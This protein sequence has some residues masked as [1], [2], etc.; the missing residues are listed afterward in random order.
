MV[1]KPSSRERPPTCN[2]CTQICLWPNWSKKCFTLILH[3]HSFSVP[4][5]SPTPGVVM[6][7]RLN[8]LSEPPGIILWLQYPNWRNATTHAS[9]SQS[10]PLSW[11]SLKCWK[12]AQQ[13]KLVASPRAPTNKQESFLTSHP[14]LISGSK[15]PKEQKS[16]CHLSHAK[17]GDIPSGLGL[18]CQPSSFLTHCSNHTFLSSAFT[19][20]VLTL[21][22]EETFIILRGGG[23]LRHPWAL[24]TAFKWHHTENPM[25]TDT[26]PAPLPLREVNV[27]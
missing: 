7:F 27:G 19:S 12:L 24:N 8:C 5:P 16:G 4:G 6:V 3:S 15:W 26:Q 21:L 13:V 10:H 1:C 25:L 18:C 9:L 23:Y 20:T 17:G 11:N 14:D 22:V 2:T